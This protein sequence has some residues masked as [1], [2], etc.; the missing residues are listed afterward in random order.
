M[1]DIPSELILYICNFC[2]YET[3]TVF[4][5]VSKYHNKIINAGRILF[6]KSNEKMMID[7]LFLEYDD[8]T[9]FVLPKNERIIC[10]KYAKSKDGLFGEEFSFIL[11]TIYISY[12]GRISLTV[13]KFGF[14]GM[15]EEEIKGYIYHTFTFSNMFDSN[16]INIINMA[17]MGTYY[18]MGKL[19]DIDKMIDIPIYQ[20]IIQCLKCDKY[21]SNYI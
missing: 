4:Q 11:V 5:S 6:E 3:N 16:T 21:N 10:Q 17:G 12:T 18:N 8:K 19:E 7:N 14:V 2:S 13:R 9:Q 1:N 20:N 15:F